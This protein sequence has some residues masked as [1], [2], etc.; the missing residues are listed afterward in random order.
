VTDLPWSQALSPCTQE[1]SWIVA[2]RL[3]RTLP[4][5]LDML[6]R[7]ADEISRTVPDTALSVIAGVVRF[8][9]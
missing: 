1:A 3:R 6:Q 7:R 8:D 5:A 2:A 4:E 9:G